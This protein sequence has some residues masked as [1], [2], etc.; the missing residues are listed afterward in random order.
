MSMLDKA[1]EIIKNKD[2]DSNL[3]ELY[4][5]IAQKMI[6]KCKPKDVVIKQEQNNLKEE[7]IAFGVNMD[8]IM[9][10]M[11]DVYYSTDSNDV[12]I[13]NYIDY[14]NVNDFIELLQDG[15]CDDFIHPGVCIE[16][17]KSDY[18]IIKFK[19]DTYNTI[20]QGSDSEDF[21]EVVFNNNFDDIKDCIIETCKMLHGKIRLW[22]CYTLLCEYINDMDNDME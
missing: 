15:K 22:H 20:I 13:Y 21:C 6:R 19:N 4:S 7:L 12:S 11:L 8:N 1:N 2:I 14:I 17:E 18:S 3:T 16:S 10:D 5:E 9:Q